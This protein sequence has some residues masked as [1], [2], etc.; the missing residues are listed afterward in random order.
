MS[1]QLSV[2]V[3]RGDITPE[4]GAIL[5]GYAPGRPATSIHD[6]LHFTAFAF[7]QDGV[8]AIVATA[9]LC[10]IG[11]PMMG[12]IRHAMEESSGVPYDNIIVSS[13][14]THSGPVSWHTPGNYPVDYDYLYN[15]LVPETAKAAADAVS[16]LRPAVMGVG[17][18]Q[19]DVGVNR[20]ELTLDG[21]IILGQ[22]PEGSYDPT[23]TV[24]SFREPDGKPIG[25]M[26]HY[27]AHNTGSG[28][29]PEITR[30]WSGV[31]IDRLEAES[32][33]V[34]A[35]FNGCEGDCG[36]RLANGKTTGNLQL[37]LELG[38]R[39]AIDA[40]RAWR[41]IR[42]WRPGCGLR[43]STD[44]V[45][46]FRKPLP[47]LEESEARLKELGDPEKLKGTGLRESEY[48]TVL[49]RIRAVKE[50]IEIP[51]SLEIAQ[52]IVSVGPVAFL[53]IPFETFSGIT[54]RISRHSP[55]AHTLSLS[56]GNGANG[57]F[58]TQDQLC[59]GGYEVWMFSSMRPRP[60][61]DDSDQ[62]Y[63]T[64]SV[65]LLQKLFEADK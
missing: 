27:G 57:Y 46:V 15:K 21:K 54:L 40:V 25:N 39:A 11:E 28:K 8:R 45:D 5:Q 17:V 16:S 58:P 31:M 36:P 65:K 13:T 10:Q 38:G 12:K 50:N 23:M 43:V 29:N 49:E 60:F 18:T 24:V 42:E 32:G 34:T 51:D 55:F 20:R 61:R 35:F 3:G 41:S 9:E 7:E 64:E 56:N 2:G 4:I 33:G 44:R 47:T 19:S 53:P 52:T 26:I 37:A 30:D 48:K 14:H 6:H 22:D 1:S 63:V 59:R 62:H